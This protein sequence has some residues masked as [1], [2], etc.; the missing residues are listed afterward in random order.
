MVKFWNWLFAYETAG[1]RARAGATAV[2]IFVLGSATGL[3]VASAYSDIRDVEW[4]WTVL[5]D[6][7]VGVAALAAAIGGVATL[8]Q[9]TRADQRAEW[10]KRAERCGDYLIEG[11]ADTEDDTY[12]LGV[13][14]LR[15]LELDDSRTGRRETEYLLALGAAATLDAIDRD[16]D[17]EDDEG[18]T[19]E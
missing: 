11:N 9:R 18:G 4:N 16:D 12:R 2:M 8:M 17:N 3:L 10:W 19:D 15:A 7:A 13:G 6:V 5:A 1:D 14:L